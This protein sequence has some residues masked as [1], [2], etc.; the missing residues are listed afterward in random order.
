MTRRRTLLWSATAAGL[1]ALLI[2]WFALQP[3]ADQAPGEHPNNRANHHPKSAGG[4]P[5]N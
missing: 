5:S 3:G 4:G 2:G 1:S